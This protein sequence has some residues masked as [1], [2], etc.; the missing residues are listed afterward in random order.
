MGSPPRL[1][2][3]GQRGSL[4]HMTVVWLALV[5]FFAVK[6][7]KSGKSHV[8]TVNNTDLD[9]VQ[10]DLAADSL[11]ELFEWYTVA[12]DISQRAISNKYNKDKEVSLTECMWW[13]QNRLKGQYNFNQQLF[14]PTE[15]KSPRELRKKIRYKVLTLKMLN[16]DEKNEKKQHYY[17][18]YQFKIVVKRW[19]L[20]NWHVPKQNVRKHNTPCAI[21]WGHPPHKGD[22]K[23][24]IDQPKSKHVTMF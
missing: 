14:I 17:L 2:V 22:T 11:E 9:S 10:F 8:L 18:L 3:P 7:G 12:W 16:I 19:Y 20:K 13:D 21:L 1:P 15:N 5:S 6:S 24:Q 23:Q 4:A